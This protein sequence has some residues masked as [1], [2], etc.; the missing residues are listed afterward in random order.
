MPELIEASEKQN[1]EPAQ[2]YRSLGKTGTDIRDGLCFYDGSLVKDDWN[3][4]RD[5]FVTRDGDIK[6]YQG[7]Y[8]TSKFNV[9][10]YITLPI[11]INT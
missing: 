7:S 4:K 8:D 9:N 3:P 5:R 11:G 1:I 2:T 10:T 6:P